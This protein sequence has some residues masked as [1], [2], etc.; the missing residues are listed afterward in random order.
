MGTPTGVIF[1]TQRYSLHD[2]PGIRTTLF[3][4]GCPLRCVW[5]HNPESQSPLPEMMYWEARCTACG[6]CAAACH[7]GAIQLTGAG[8]LHDPQRCSA[9]G[10]CVDRCPSGARGIAGRIVT[11][12]QALREILKDRVFFDESGGGVTFSG[13]EPLS[14]PEFLEETLRLCK[15][16]GLAATLDTSGFAPWPTLKRIISL[17]DLFLYDVKIMDEAAHRKYVGASNEIILENLK[18]LRAAG[19]RVVARVPLIPGVNDTHENIQRTGEFLASVPVEDVDVL[20]YHDMGAEKY[21]RLG[22]DYALKDVVSPSGERI[23]EIVSQLRGFGLSAR[24]G[25]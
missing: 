4:K 19:K 8:L 17:V 16:E 25:G 18:R 2:G 3:F 6:A 5:C 20:P 10:A 11:P 21:R 14:Q 15:E 13:G 23:D 22:R 9:C 24:S 7:R 1:N 12:Q